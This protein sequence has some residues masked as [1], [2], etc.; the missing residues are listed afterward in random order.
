MSLLSDIYEN[1]SGGIPLGKT[2]FSYNP[3]ANIRANPIS[4]K[5]P[6]ATPPV[7]PPVIP[8]VT[9]PE[10]KQVTKTTNTVTKP[11]FNATNADAPIDPMSYQQYINPATGKMYTPAEM[12]KIELARSKG[13]ATD[14]YMQNVG[15]NTENTSES[16]NREGT[17][18]NNARN[19]I[20]T[21]TTDPYKV[22][23]QSGL[24]YTAQELNAIEK[25]YA[26]IYDPALAD[27]FAK[28][29][30]KQKADQKKIDD[31]DWV[32]KQIFSTNESIR[33]WRETT[34]TKASYGGSNFTATQTNK[35]ASNAGMDIAT[36]EA[37]DP[38]LKNYFV[39]TPNDVDEIS[40]KSYKLTDTLANLLKQVNSGEATAEEFMLFLEEKALPEA[41]K[42][43]YI[44]KMNVP[45]EVKQG[46]LKDV[47]QGVKGWL[48]S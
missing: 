42:T 12:A 36:F 15:L 1:V 18:L 46:W 44:N 39:N 6:V 40:G 24:Q 13:G 4:Y 35:G 14:N 45:E 38:D 28:I 23:S 34:G 25:A 3:L 5:A 48:T 8:P 10:K 16:L 17:A 2:G 47:W 43:Y 22:A 30:A 27:V 41:V 37:L 11:I 21:G 9:P 33:Q 7:V 32:K 20:A 26:G 19:D 29:D 31:E